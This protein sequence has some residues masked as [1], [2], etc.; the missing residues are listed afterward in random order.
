MQ[1]RL[2]KFLSQAGVASRRAADRLIEEGRV[3]VNG[4]VVQEL[5]SKIDD[6]K[7]RVK[8]DGKKIEKDERLVYILLNKPAGYLVT[9]KDPFGRPTVLDFLPSLKKRVFPV[10]R[11]DSDSEGILLLTNDGELANRLT[12]PRYNIKKTYI[13]KIKG[14]PDLARLIKLEKGIFLD[15]EKTA[16]AKVVLLAHNPKKS[17]LKIEIHEGRK[18]EVRRM[19]EAIGHTVLELRR[20][21]FAGLT[22][23][24]LKS[25][26]WRYLS[27]NEVL[28]LKEKVGLK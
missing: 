27:G 16:P 3:K 22:L 14:E 12:H 15:G 10:G 9:L 19:C 18:R 7:D 17:L 2:N 26:Q 1:I 6:Q 5:G 28:K 4:R 13:V 24:K 8:I 11:L 23:G 20:I 25:R 21:A